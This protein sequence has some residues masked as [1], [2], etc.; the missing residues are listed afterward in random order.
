QLPKKSSTVGCPPR[1]ADT[2]TEEPPP[3][4]MVSPGKDGAGDPTCGAAPVE[5]EPL[6][7][8][9]LVNKKIPMI[10]ASTMP[11][12]RKILRGLRAST[13][14]STSP[15]SGSGAGPPSPGG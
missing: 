1:P 13:S 4:P 2:E 6:L 9:K 7:V 10:S 11:T 8:P 3:G 12:T 14:T 5:P 15:G